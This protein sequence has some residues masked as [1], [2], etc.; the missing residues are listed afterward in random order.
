MIQNYPREL[1]DDSWY[2]ES[3]PQLKQSFAEFT[4]RSAYLSN[5]KNIERINR[6]ALD[7][8]EQPNIVSYQ[9]RFCP[10][11]TKGIESFDVIFANNSKYDV[12]KAKL[13]AVEDYIAQYVNSAHTTFLTFSTDVTGANIGVKH[14]HPLMNRDRCNVWSFCLPLYINPDHLDKNPEFCVT[15]QQDPFPP[16][17]YLDYD[18]IKSANYNYGSYKV[19]LDDKVYSIRFDGSRSPHYIDYKPHVFVWFVF[20][21]VEFK[22]TKHRPEGTQ[23]ITELL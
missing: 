6:L 23:F 10:D 12:I 4:P 13:N 15:S 20:D 18:R 5:K 7:Q 14:L 17:W 8:S 16:R 11:K 19:P 22:D 9:T 2:T 21:G 1:F 3:I